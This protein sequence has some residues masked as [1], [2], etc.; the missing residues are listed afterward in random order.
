[1]SREAKEGVIALSG[2]QDKFS[3]IEVNCQTDFVAKNNDFINF[4][5]ELSELN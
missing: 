3:V 5:K 4:F 2:D 1:M